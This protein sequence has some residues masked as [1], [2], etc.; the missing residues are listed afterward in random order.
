MNPLYFACINILGG[1]AVFLYGV[2]E[3]T[4]AFGSSFGGRSKDIMVRFTR[5]KP[6]AFLFGMVLSA[7]AQGST[8]A[9]SFAIG[10]VDVGMLSFAGSVVVMM[11]AS[12][13]GTFVTFLLSL[14]IAAFSPLLFAASLIMIRFGRGKTYRIGNMLRGL[15]LV[16]LGMFILKLGVGPFLATPGFAELASRAGSNGLITGLAA[17][18]ATAVLQS[19]SAVMALSV[20]LATSGAMPVTAVLPVI[21]GAH[22]GS[23]VTVLLAGL[24]GRQNA[25]KLGISTFVYKVLGVLF[26]IPALPWLQELLADAPGTLAAKIVLAQVG[27]TLFN[28]L[29]FYP[30]ADYLAAFCGA[31]AE[32]TGRERL[33]APVYLDDDLLDVPSLAILL[34]SKEMIR[35]ANYIEMYCQI[36]FLPGQDA[37]GFE[38]LPGAIRE[39]SETCEEY[40][41]G[42][43]IPTD[44]DVL[45]ES[46]SKVS[47]SMVSFRQMA[48]ILSG[49]LRLLAEA[50][51]AS[52]LA[53]E[54]G[55][56]TWVELSRVA[57]TDIRLALRAFALA[58]VDFAAVAG[59]YEREFENLDRRIRLRLGADALN[60][61]ELAPLLDFLSQIFLLVKTSL[62]IARGEAYMEGA[63]Q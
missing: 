20:T 53:R 41:Y 62:E 50:G 2:E 3:T 42:I 31:V 22:A 36:L 1:L 54:L 10:F 5:R 46:Y 59:R 30:L 19:S 34:L 18:A 33:S 35:L 45:R 38:E 8:V 39:L 43:H 28:A 48:K 40:M 49:E 56:N 12:V 11:G 52:Q 37:K 13:G 26:L 51:V 21:L 61:R 27:V 15:S 25:R 29:V 55:A 17:F 6:L 44:D 58:D 14:D 57:M 23:S 16:L 60:R 32:K 47:Y 63:R 4:A 7:V 9:T 24:S